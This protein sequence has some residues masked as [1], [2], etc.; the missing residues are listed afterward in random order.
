[1][2]S[3]CL[4]VSLV[5]HH[6]IAT[7]VLLVVLPLSY[8]SPMSGQSYRHSR[9]NVFFL[10]T[11]LS[12]RDITVRIRLLIAFKFLVMLS[13]MSLVL[14]SPMLTPL[15]SRLIFLTFFGL[16]L[17]LFPLCLHYHHHLLHRL[18]L[19]YYHHI[20]PFYITIL[21][22]HILHHLLPLSPSVLDEPTCSAKS[23]FLSL[24]PIEM[25]L[26]S[27]SLLWLRR[28]LLLSIPTLG[29]LF[30]A[31]LLLFQSRASGSTRSILALMV[32]LST[33]KRILLLVVFSS[34]MIMTTRRLSLLLLT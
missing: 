19:H 15:I 26:M 23:A 14:F 34:S 10:V 21:V 29:I 33:L 2:V 30:H 9:F 32:L 1:M 18:P 22:V 24:P 13:L 27:G 6:S 12:V 7:F 25:L 4:S 28:L 5:G 16:H 8:F 11:T 3:L 31:L 17:T 20:L